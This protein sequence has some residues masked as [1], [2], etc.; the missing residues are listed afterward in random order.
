MAFILT[1][2]YHNKSRF[3]IILIGE[4]FGFF[5]GEHHNKNLSLIVLS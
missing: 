1:A 2:D 3:H 5:I 4:E